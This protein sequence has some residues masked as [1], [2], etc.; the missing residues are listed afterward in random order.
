MATA[1][2]I[3]DLEQ[4]EADLVFKTFDEDTAIMIGMALVEAGKANKAPIVIDI[5]TPDR[6][7]FHAALAGSAPD[8]DQWALRKSNF[9]LR[10]HCSSMLGGRR[11]KEAGKTVGPELGLDLITYAAHGGSVP[12]RV[13]GVGVIGAITVSGL[14]SAEDHSMVVAAMTAVLE[15]LR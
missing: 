11:L 9:A 6:T 5:R 12:I 3:K 14:A 10:M 13:A 15:T 1:L 8:N 7:L 2:S 4:Q